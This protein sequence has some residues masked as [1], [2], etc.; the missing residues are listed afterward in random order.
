MATLFRQYAY[1][2]YLSPA[3]SFRD[4]PQRCHCLPKRLFSRKE[5][6]SNPRTGFA[7]YTLSRRASSAT[8]APFPNTLGCKSRYFFTNNGMSV[9]LFYFFNPNRSLDSESVSS[10]GRQM[11]CQFV[12]GVADYGRAS[13]Q[14]RCRQAGDTG[15]K[16]LQS[17]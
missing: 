5:G 6:D 8:R 14:T 9:T 4:G 12:A 15:R 11:V 1:R 13:G 2:E 16:V 3:I 7:G 17:A 10:A